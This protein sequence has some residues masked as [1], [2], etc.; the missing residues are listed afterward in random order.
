MQPSS[1]LSSLLP[2][3]SSPSQTQAIAFD[4]VVFCTG[5]QAA[6]L[7]SPLGVRLP[8]RPVYGYS[9]S[10]HIKEPMNAPRSGL[11]DEH[12]KVSITRLGQR[13]RV[14]GSAQVG[15]SAGQMNR[16]AIQTLYKV[17]HDWFPGAAVMSQGVQEWQG[18]RPMLANRPPVISR[19]VKNGNVW[20]NLGHG[21]SG[22]AL[23]CGSA[24]LL[25]DKIAGHATELDESPFALI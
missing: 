1:Q 15:G 9:V 4:G 24:R 8:L 14:A 23:S 19:A 6:P 21:S 22:W 18:A 5:V 7:L 2:A 20:L 3:H 11:M 25:A 13:V 17:L 12:Y 16:A 10:A